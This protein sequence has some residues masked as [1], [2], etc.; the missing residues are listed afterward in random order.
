M[1]DIRHLLGTLVGTAK[2][3]RAGL[4][5]PPVFLASK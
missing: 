2:A 3:A 4:L 1:A 5:A